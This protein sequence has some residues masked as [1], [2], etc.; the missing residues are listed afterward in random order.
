[1]KEKTKGVLL[2]ALGNPMY[3]Q[4]AANLAASLKINSPE[5]PVHL[6]WGG[7]ALSHLTP[8]KL[9]L[10]GSMAECPVSLYHR[11]GVPSYV[12]PK[13]FMFELSPFDETIFLDVDTIIAPK[14]KFTNLFT[15]LVDVDFTFENRSRVNLAEIRDSD[16]YL[17]GSI[18]DIKKAYKLNEGYL[19]GLHSEFVYFKRNAKMRAFFSTAQSVF[20]NPKVKV[21]TFGQDIPDEFGFAIAMLKHKMYPHQ[22][23]YVPFYWQLTDNKKGISLSYV[24]DNFYGYSVGGNNPPR[25][26]RQNY[27]QMAGAYFRIL[28]LKYPYKLQPKKQVLAERKTL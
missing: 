11:N 20:E 26:V 1:M 17:W 18:D 9:S 4:L 25:N 16:T 22:C 24:I 3:G 14:K 8:E 12:K 13:L 6:V 15:E 5:L 27:D 28:G 21:K 19:Y 23:P 2:I 7:L 10:F